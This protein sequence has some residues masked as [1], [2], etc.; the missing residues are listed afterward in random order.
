MKWSILAQILIPG[1][2]LR[3][4][5]YSLPRKIEESVSSPC[6]HPGQNVYHHSSESFPCSLFLEKLLPSFST[7]KTHLSDA[8]SLSEDSN[9]AQQNYLL[10]LN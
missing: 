1:M 3:P 6:P 10:P 5:G 4:Q 2:F 9:L 7:G 8:F